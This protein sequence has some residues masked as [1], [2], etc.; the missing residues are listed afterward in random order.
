MKDDSSCEKH[1][2]LTCYGNFPSKWNYSK[3][4]CYL[5]LL[6]IGSCWMLFSMTD[7]ATRTILIICLLFILYCQ[8][9]LGQDYSTFCWADY[10]CWHWLFLIHHVEW[11]KVEVT[12]LAVAKFVLAVCGDYQGSRSLV[13]IVI[14]KSFK[15][16]EWRFLICPHRNSPE[17]VMP[18]CDVDVVVFPKFHFISLFYYNI[19]QMTTRCLVQEYKWSLA[20]EI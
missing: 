2:I 10:C 19:K 9:M 6:C 15:Y 16:E 18:I 20:L 5:L 14:N 11:L 17:I 7:I 3:W 8:I 12:H 1:G 13:G 4:C